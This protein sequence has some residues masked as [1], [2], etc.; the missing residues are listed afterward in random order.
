MNKLQKISIALVSLLTL[1]T[2]ASA[3]VI[4]TPVIRNRLDVI[5]QGLFGNTSTTTISGDN[6]VSTFNGSIVVN[7]TATSTITNLKVNNLEIPVVGYTY[8]NFLAPSFT[9]TSTTATSSFLGWVGIGTSNPLVRFEV[10]GGATQTAG[11]LRIDT[12]GN[13]LVTIG[14]LDGTTGRN[15]TFK[16]MDRVGTVK[17]R[18]NNASAGS[19]YYGNFSLGYGVKILQATAD[20]DSTT[21]GLFEVNSAALG[22][23]S[24]IFTGGNVGIGTTSPYSLLSVTGNVVAQNFTATSTTATTTLSGG[25]TLTGKSIYPT[26]EKSFGNFGSTTPDYAYNKFNT[27]TTSAIVWNS[28]SAIAGISLFCKTNNAGT[29]TV[30][31]GNGTA[32]TTLIATNAGVG[33][34]SSVTWTA[35][36]NL[37]FALKTASGSPDVVTCTGTFSNN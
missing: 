25:L 37:I 34:T 6:G 31:M 4:D 13:G 17:S 35:R 30:E 2:I 29:V 33:V 14:R 16:F 12:S 36:Q 10:T 19:I 3:M 23:N 11:D 15:T 22:G 20:V 27:S 24:A 5:G 32:S 18:W 1:G 21:N 9:A 28:S 26:F 7:G 8:S